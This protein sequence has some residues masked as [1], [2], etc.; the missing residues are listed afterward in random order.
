MVIINRRIIAAVT[1]GAVIVLLS[2]CASNAD[3]P[4][5]TSES[6]ITTESHGPSQTEI[7]A[8]AV[9]KQAAD[10]QAA[11][12]AKAAADAEAAQAA[13]EA[14]AAADAAADAQTAADAQAQADADAQA[15]ADT[16]AEADAQAPAPAEAY[17]QPQADSAPAAQPQNDASQRAAQY[18][19]V[20]APGL[21]IDS[22]SRTCGQFASKVDGVWTDWHEV[23][24]G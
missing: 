8:A 1:V 3:G 18:G 5:T 24:C 22:F 7:E 20:A 14:Q 9:A 15:E 23:P 4:P 19:V 12:Q 21:Q 17:S 13:S 10:V 11:A 6:V 16:Q 2:G